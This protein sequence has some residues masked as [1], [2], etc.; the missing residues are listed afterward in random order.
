MDQ[1]AGKVAVVTGGSQG[2]GAATVSRLARGGALVVITD[3]RLEAN[4]ADL[5]DDVRRSEGRLD[6][7]VNNA[8]VTHRA[9]S[10]TPA[11]RI[12]TGS[13]PSVLRALGSASGHAHT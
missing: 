13:S 3:V 5:V 11:P 9:G 8:A 2:I 12:G 6:V 4:W 7:L 1:L 10:A